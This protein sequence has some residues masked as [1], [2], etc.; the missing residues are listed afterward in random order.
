MWTILG[1]LLAFILGIGV[2]KWEEELQE[3]AHTISEA[4]KDNANED[5]IWGSEHWKINTW[6]R[7]F[8]AMK[9]FYFSLIMLLGLA[10]FI[11]KGIVWCWG[12][13]WCWG[14]TLLGLGFRA[15]QWR[16]DEEEN[17][18]RKDARNVAPPYPAYYLD[19]QI[20]AVVNSVLLYGFVVHY[21]KFTESS[22]FLLI[23]IPIGFYLGSVVKLIA[24][25][26]RPTLLYI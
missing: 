10:L 24:S 2:I 18:P 25:V 22:V 11:P 16:N 5:T 23:T 1:M 21:L 13:L 4:V 19:Y 3:K 14:C 6:R 20:I 9:L 7:V 26:V 12:I 8:T 17:D 15:W